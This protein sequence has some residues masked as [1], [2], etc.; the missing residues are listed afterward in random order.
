MANDS[1]SCMSAAGKKSNAESSD[2][3]IRLRHLTQDAFCFAARDRTTSFSNE[4]NRGG[5]KSRSC[6]PRSVLWVKGMHTESGDRSQLHRSHWQ[7][8]PFKHL[9][10]WR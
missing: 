2:S 1:M 7:Q 10:S 3:K 4:G 8:F 9:E 6:L 5:K